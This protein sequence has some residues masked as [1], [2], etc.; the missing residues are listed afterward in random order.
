MRLGHIGKQKKAT[1]LAKWV[2][3]TAYGSM[4]PPFGATREERLKNNDQ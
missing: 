3:Q 4:L 1:V 2:R